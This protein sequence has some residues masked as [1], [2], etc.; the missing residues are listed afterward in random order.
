MNK[1]QAMKKRIKLLLP[2]IK[3]IER[4]TKPHRPTERRQLGTLKVSRQ[5]AIR[6]A[7]LQTMFDMNVLTHDEIANDPFYMKEGDMQ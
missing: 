6:M 7:F 5:R 1:R 4:A 3:Q 2:L